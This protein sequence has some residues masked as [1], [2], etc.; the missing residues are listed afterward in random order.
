M[1]IRSVNTS[2]SSNKIQSQS[3]LQEPFL[4]TR[5]SWENLDRIIQN[6]SAMNFDFARYMLAEARKGKKNPTLVSLSSEVYRKQL[7]KALNMNRTRI[8]AFKNKLPTRKETISNEFASEAKPSKPSR[9]NPKT[10]ER[11]LNARHIVDDYYLNLLD[12]GSSNVLSLALGNTVYMWDASKGATSALVTIDEEN[13]PVTNVKCAPDG[14]HIIVGLNNSE[15][16]IWDSTAARQLR[17]LR[18]VHG[19]RV[20]LT[21]GGMDGKIINNDVRVRAHVVETYRGHTQEVCGLKLSASGSKLAS[22]RNDNLLHI[23]D[24]TMASSNSPTRWLHRLEEHTAAV[25]A[26]GWCPFQGNLLASGGGGSD[27]CIKFWN[28][29]TGVCLNSV[30]TGS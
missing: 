2:A 20:G 23:W 15:V 9:R 7:A 10:S 17:T 8:L 16:Q 14:G 24:R 28:M 26:L 3:P 18:G 1:K 13:G 27:R 29:H 30:D 21:T 19:S 11:T 12:W 4:Q 5:S 25:K 22:G 6:R